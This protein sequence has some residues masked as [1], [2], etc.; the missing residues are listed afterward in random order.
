MSISKPLIMIKLSHIKFHHG[1]AITFE[2][3]VTVYHT[4]NG[5]VSSAIFLFCIIF[6]HEEKVGGK[7]KAT[8][9]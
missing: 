9:K 4:G 1:H 3:K 2:I 5:E 7:I 6:G 8:E